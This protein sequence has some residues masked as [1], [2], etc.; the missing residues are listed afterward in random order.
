MFRESVRSI[1]FPLPTVAVP[2]SIQ[3]SPGE[4]NLHHPVH[5]PTNKISVLDRV[6]SGL[7]STQLVQHLTR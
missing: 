5:I 7:L 6:D 3:V 4:K 1:S 2:L